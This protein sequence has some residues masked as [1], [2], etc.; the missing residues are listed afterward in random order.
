MAIKTVSDRVKKEKT[1]TPAPKKNR[2][3][4]GVTWSSVPPEYDKK[5]V[6]QNG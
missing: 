4:A 3:A 2:D 5:G 6:K 1:E